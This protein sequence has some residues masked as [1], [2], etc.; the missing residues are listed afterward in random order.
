M[1][2]AQKKIRRLRIV[3]RKI[4]LIQSWIRVWIRRKKTKQEIIRSNKIGYSSFKELQTWLQEEW[5]FMKDTGRV[6]LHYN[7]IGSD[8]LEKLSMEKLEQKQNLQIGRIFNL[9]SG[10]FGSSLP[11]G[12]IEVIYVCSCQVPDDV[13]RYYYKV[14]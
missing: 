6:E 3:L 13:I 8:E 11:G 10:I 12:N 9:F 5:S 14:L 4:K 1:K 7:S 2:L